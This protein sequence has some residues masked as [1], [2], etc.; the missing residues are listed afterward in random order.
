M[1][2]TEAQQSQL[3][4]LLSSYTPAS[5]PSASGGGSVYDEQAVRYLAAI[6]KSSAENGS[7]YM[8]DKKVAEVLRSANRELDRSEEYYSKGANGKRGRFYG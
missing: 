2:L 8:D 7:I 3:F 1:I 4:R 6:A 5:Q